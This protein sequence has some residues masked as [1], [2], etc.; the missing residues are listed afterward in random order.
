MNVIFSNVKK[1]KNVWPLLL[2]LAGL[3]MSFHRPILGLISPAKLD[4][5]IQHAP[6]I[7]PSVY[8]VYAN[9]NAMEGKYS[10]FKMLV[11]NNSNNPARNVEVSFQIPNYIDWNQVTKFPVIL[12]GQSVA[13]SYTHLTLPTT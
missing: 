10:L 2:V 6:I 13:V 11:T 9:D 4:L 12:P 3:L 7:M 5:Q 1:K 8:K